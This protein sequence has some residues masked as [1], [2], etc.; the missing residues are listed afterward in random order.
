[1]GTEMPSHFRGGNPETQEMLSHL[2]MKLSSDRTW[3]R[4]LVC[5]A[6]LGPQYFPLN[7]KLE[8]ELNSLRYKN[9]ER[10]NFISCSRCLRRQAILVG[11]EKEILI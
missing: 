4:T 6:Y 5:D 3:T 8:T 10:H 7:L 11:K 1:M 9:E 2:P